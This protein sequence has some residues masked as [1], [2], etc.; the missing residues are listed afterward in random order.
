MEN[1]NVER[2]NHIFISCLYSYACVY[3]IVITLHKLLYYLVFSM[4]IVTEKFPVLLQIICKQILI[5]IK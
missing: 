4:N 5:A 3:V 1:R 2:K